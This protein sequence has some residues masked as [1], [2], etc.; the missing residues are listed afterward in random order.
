MY[1]VGATEVEVKSTEEAFEVLYHG[2]KQRRVAQTQLNQESSR[3]HSVFTVRLVQA[4]L[5]HCGKDV[6]QVKIIITHPDC[7]YLFESCS[8]NLEFNNANTFLPIQ[9]HILL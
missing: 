3:S 1:V 9:Y 4:P 2:Q 7:L 8:P 6:L 5:D